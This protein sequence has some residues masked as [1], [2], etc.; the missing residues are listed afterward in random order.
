MSDNYI[1]LP[2]NIVWD[3][4]NEESLCKYNNK[5]LSAICYLNFS[6]NLAGSCCFTLDDMITSCGLVTRTGLGNTIDQFKLI[7]KD[8]QKMQWLDGKL[9]IDS[10]K[11]KQFI[12][13]N[14][15]PIFKKDDMGNDTEF[16]K[17]SYDKYIKIMNDNS[18][19]DKSITL[20]VFCYITARMRRN[21]KEGQENRDI[22]WL[23]DTCVECFYEKYETICEDL[24]I[25][26]TTLTNNINLLQNL[27]LIFF[28]NIGLVKYKNYASYPANNVYAET[29]EY[30]KYGLSLSKKYY[31]ESGFEIIG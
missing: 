16:F 23:E 24:D 30:L 25:S 14:F 17:L 8:L 22:H 5:L 9:N 26:E 6:I 15:N 11:P 31:K 29:E 27:G 10:I 4:N 18:K 7:L 20:K 19:L 28:G 13:C 12:K 21:T 2:N 1:K 3:K